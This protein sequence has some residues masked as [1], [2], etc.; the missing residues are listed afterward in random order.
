MD[1]KKINIK[2]LIFLFLLLVVGL[3]GT[4]IAY[5]SSERVIVNEFKTSTYN[6]VIEEEFYDTWGTKKVSFANKEETNV[7]VV[8]RINY[9]E[10]WRYEKD[11]TKFSLDNN[12]NGE[13]LVTKNWTSEFTNDFIAGEDGWFYYKKILN[14]EESIQVLESIDLK[15]DLVISSTYSEEYSIATYEL[16]FNFEA[17]QAN[18]EAISKIWGKNANF[19][20]DDITWQI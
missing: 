14:A 11:G 8:L 18:T 17:I 13:N 19:V 10:F 16:D 12:V 4:T 7:S 3:V 9:N 2:S 1:N 5:F 6:V 15:D 20:G